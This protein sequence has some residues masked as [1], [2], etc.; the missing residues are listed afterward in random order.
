MDVPW[1]PG[2]HFTF[3]R[4]GST[5]KFNH[6]IEFIAAD[7]QQITRPGKSFQL[8]MG[9]PEERPLA[10]IAP[11]LYSK[12]KHI[13]KFIKIYNDLG[14]D[15]LKTC[16]SPM[17]LLKPKTR[18]QVVAGQMLDFLQANPRHTKVSIHAFSV[19]GYLLSE[20][21]VKMDLEA[22]QY[23]PLLDRFVGQIWDSAVDVRGLPIGVARSMTT[24]SALQR[25]LVASF[26]FF[27]W[28]ARPQRLAY[29]SASRRFHA[30]FLA[31][32]SLF[33]SSKGD[34]ISPPEMHSVVMDGW[35]K[36]DRTVFTKVFEKSAHVGHYSRYK[37]EYEEEVH[38]FLKFIEITETSKK[39]SESDEELAQLIKHTA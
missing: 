4:H 26:E 30:G 22:E 1:L 34:P 31:A 36:M 32:P 21:L 25:L 28:A 19:G 8:D 38:K 18:S 14:I 16:I 3:V 23:G 24:N 17:E 7:T 12:P 10:I 20:A 11:W 15:V 9:G 29:E 37:E 33:F 13:N 6:N 5:F 39:S 27:L 35:R 2:A